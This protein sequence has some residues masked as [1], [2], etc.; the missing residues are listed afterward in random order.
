[1]ATVEA[2]AVAKY[3]RMSPRKARTVIDLIRGKPVEEALRVLRFTPRKSARIIEKTLRSAVAN[4]KVID[5]TGRLSE[6]DLVVTKAVIDEGSPL[7]RF[8][9]AAMG[10]ASVIKRRTSHVSVMVSGEARQAPKPARRGRKA[11]DAEAE[12][13]GGGT[14]DK[15]KSRRAQLGKGSRLG[16]RA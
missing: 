9:P 8:R 14:K 16:A 15:K 13:A 1:M 2:R 10:R 11:A 7:K 12:K 5:G 3:V 6:G 4:A